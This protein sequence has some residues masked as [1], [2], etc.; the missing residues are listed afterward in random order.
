MKILF[1][2]VGIAARYDRK[3]AIKLAEE[4]V[5][6]LQGKGLEVYVENTL[7]K[8]VQTGE[9]VPLE[10]MKTDLIITI[11][12][13]GTILRTCVSIPK[14]EPPILAIN[15]G[16]RGF[17]TEVE[18]KLA[19]TAVDK[20]LNGDYVIEKCMKLTT[21]ADGS[22]FPDA[23]N[24]V[25]ITHDEPAK[26][27]YT[28]I[29]KDNKPI[30]TCQA[31]SLLISTQ[32]GSTGYS[33]SAG[34]P[35]L[36]PSVDAFVLTPIC[37]LT[38]FRSVVFPGNSS[39]TVEVLRPN[40]MLVLIDGQFNRLISSKLPTVTVTRSKNETSFIRF[41]DNFYN[42]LRSRLLFKGMR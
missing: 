40:K 41:T 8:M 14:P 22:K 4:L 34:G 20:C 25:L 16:I 10:R 38:D 42:R 9:M 6:H 15:M 31:D 13:D 33:L 27:L 18:P 39:L 21:R 29:L 35:V 17:L 28:R 24:E 2:T 3:R 36:D 11:G 12:G 7:A 32:T 30:L 19:F 5:Q 37:P 23:L 1:K 26:L